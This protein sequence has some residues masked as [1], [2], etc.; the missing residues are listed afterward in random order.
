MNVLCISPGFPPN[1]V[2]FAL[3]LSRAG[4]TVLGLG[5]VPWDELRPDLRDALA[6]YYYLPSLAD[7]DAMLKATAHLIARH[8]RIDRL[9]SHTEHW[10]EID[11][12]LRDDFDIP[13][14]RPADLAKNRHKLGMKRIFREQGI[15]C[16]EGIAADKP[17]NVRAFAKAHG[18]PLILKPDVGAGAAGAMRVANTSQLEAALDSLPEGYLVEAVL[19]GD[20]VSFDGLVDGEGR[21]LFF[22]SHEFSAGILETVAEARPFHYH[23][24]REVDPRLEALGRRVVAAFGIRERF[25]HVEFFRRAP[26]DYAALEVNVR[27]PGGP[28]IDLMNLSSDIDLFQAWADLLVHGRWP[29]P[30]QRLYHAAWVGRRRGVPYAFSDLQLRERHGALLVDTVEQPEA[31][32]AVMGNWGY[33]LRHPELARLQEAIADVEAVADARTAT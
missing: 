21:L 15:P 29:W 5:D 8:G 24:V 31:F 18:F 7:Y 12:R 14:Q 30:W 26:G 27:P 20:L 23:T 17:A 3:A 19:T 2:N 16:A 1:F 13:G 11:A 22:T 6:E 28:S 9:E 25:F 33:L 32:A 10:L 4:A